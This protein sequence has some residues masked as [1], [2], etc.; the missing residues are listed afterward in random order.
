MLYR[1]CLIFVLSTAMLLKS[2]TLTSYANDGKSPVG[3]K[4]QLTLNDVAATVNGQ[5]MTLSTPPVLLNNTT[6]VPLRFIA[7]ALKADLT[8]NTEDQSIALKYADHVIKLSIDSRFVRIDN[9]SMTL[10][11]PAVIMNSTTLVPLRFIAESLNQ[12]VAYN[13]ETKSIIITTPHPRNAEIRVD[14][15]NTASNMGFTYNF[16]I[17]QPNMNVISMASDHHN[18]IYILE[19]DAASEMSFALRV[20]NEATGETKVV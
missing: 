10:E 14:N 2:Y 9:Q 6:L 15:L 5:K 7:D 13:N 12:T 16:F 20:Y 3:V 19:Q 4:I 8:W 11:Q 1:V 18:Q 17:Q